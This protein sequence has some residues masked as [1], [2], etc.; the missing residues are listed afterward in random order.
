MLSPDSGM[1]WLEALPRDP[2]PPV[3]LYL[4]YMEPHGPYAPE[5]F[6]LEREDE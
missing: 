2:R 4:H 6:A 1:A 3:F 5:E